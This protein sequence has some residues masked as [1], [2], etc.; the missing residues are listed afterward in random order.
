VIE[1]R[2]DLIAEYDMQ[3]EVLDAYTI[4][5]DDGTTSPP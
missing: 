5:S 1:T 4:W 2:A 3:H